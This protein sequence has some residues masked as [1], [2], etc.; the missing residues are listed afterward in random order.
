MALDFKGGLAKKNGDQEKNPLWQGFTSGL[1][2]Q[3]VPED[4]EFR[5][6]VC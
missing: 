5:A 1:L 4:L 6:R 2:K 3:Q